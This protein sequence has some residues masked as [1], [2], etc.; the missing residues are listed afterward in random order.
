MRVLVCGGRDY[1]DG[2]H[3]FRELDRLHES[4]PITLVIEGGASGADLSARSWAFHRYIQ[5]V[6]VHA[7]WKLHGRAAGPI[8]NKQMLDEQSPDVVLAFPG[9]KGTADMVR[10]ATQRGVRV[11]H[12]TPARS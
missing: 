4:E 9:G 8:R 12:A 11:V 2:P 7:Q 1:D 6:T 5:H 10:Q 3:V